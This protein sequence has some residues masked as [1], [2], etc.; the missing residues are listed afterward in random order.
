MRK[1][2]FICCLVVVAYGV[3]HSQGLS[4]ISLVKVLQNCT[5]NSPNPLIELLETCGYEYR[6]TTA[7]HDYLSNGT[8]ST[9]VYSTN[10]KVVH[11][12][13]SNGL[14]YMPSEDAANA[15]IIIIRAQGDNILGADVQIYSKAGFSI[16]ISQL[17][18]MGY[19]LLSDSGTGNRGQS[20]EFSALG[21]PAVS[22]WN[23][24]SNTY[25]LTITK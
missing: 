3:V 8:L 25:V 6:F 14:E 13:C 1:F 2:I 4:A 12:E 9:Y 23:D 10:C 16:W 21:K 15:S 18:T 22:I 17:K 20:W 5:S 19:K 24:Y 7:Q 11:E